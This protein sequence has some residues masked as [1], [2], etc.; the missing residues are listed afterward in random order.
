[1]GESHA[2]V[3]VELMLSCSICCVL[4]V[5]FTDIMKCVSALPEDKLKKSLQA[6]LPSTHVYSVLELRL[7]PQFSNQAPPGAQQLSFPDFLMTSHLGH[8]GVILVTVTAGVD[9]QTLIK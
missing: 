1:M 6:C 2:A 5:W 9:M 4:V 3:A 8:T 7:V